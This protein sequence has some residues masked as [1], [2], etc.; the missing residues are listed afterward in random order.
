MNLSSMTAP[1][2]GKMCPNFWYREKLKDSKSLA[3]H[4]TRD[5]EKLSNETKSKPV[6]G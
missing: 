1:D 4:W 6:I 2:Y 5:S 3:S